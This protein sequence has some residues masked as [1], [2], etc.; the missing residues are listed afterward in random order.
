MEARVRA[1]FTD[2]DSLSDHIPLEMVRV[3]VPQTTST[4]MPTDLDD[5]ATLND[6]A[7]TI[8]SSGPPPNDFLVYPNINLMEGIN[9]D[10]EIPNIWT[11]KKIEALLERMQDENTGL[12]IKSVKSFMSKIPSVFTGGDLIQWILKTLD[13]DD[14]T[15]ALHLANLMSSCGYI[16]PIEDHVLM[17]K[18][19]GTFY[20]FQTPFFWPSSH[21]EPDNIDYAVY[22]CKRTMQNKTRLELA[23]YEAENLAR[24]QKLFAR[25]WELIYMQAEAQIK[26]D[27][28][29]DKVERNVLDSQERAFWD[30][31]RPAPGCVNMTEQDIKKLMRRKAAFLSSHPLSG[32]LRKYSTTSTSNTG[33]ASAL[34]AA[35]NKN[36][37]TMTVGLLSTGPTTT[38]NQTQNRPA[39]LKESDEAAL[40]DQLCH[41]IEFLKHRI[42]RRCLRTSKVCENYVSYF[43]QYAEFDP[44]ITPC[45][46][47]NPWLV[48]STELWELEKL[49]NAKEIST[50]R[51]KRWGFSINELLKDPIGRDHFW[52]FLDKEYSSENLRFY[53]A[54]IQLRF[55]TPQ[56]DVLKRVHEIYNEFLSPGAYYSINIDQRVMNLTKNN[57]THV[58]SRYTFDEAQDHIFNLMNR[59]TYARFLRSEAYKELLLGGKKK[60]GLKT[61]RLSIVVRTPLETISIS[62]T[63]STTGISDKYSFGT[64]SR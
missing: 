26:V 12:P 17:V 22:L 19:D 4:I 29:R 54:C 63:G 43:E 33:P 50:R 49:G 44:F 48:D 61:G 32:T 45:E 47:S 64:G 8:I 3:T 25:K 13:V 6:S 15:E 38:T 37:I 53:E 9:R 18:N 42:D 59:D 34:A 36:F 23:D 24:L 40:I 46:P 51:V 5:Q 41:E 35:A 2:D 56:K 16:L 10:Y 30:V 7:G 28:K 55:H 20:R 27:K 58:P 14:T 1:S 62:G 60:P 57:M 21:G 31:Y 11:Y 52:K 39:V